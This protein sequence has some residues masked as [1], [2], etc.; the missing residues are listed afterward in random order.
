MYALKLN[1][2]NF[3]LPKTPYTNEECGNGYMTDKEERIGKYVHRKYV[4]K[5]KRELFLDNWTV[6]E[7]E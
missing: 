1:G 7:I 4:E 2:T 5:I 3:Y 6:V